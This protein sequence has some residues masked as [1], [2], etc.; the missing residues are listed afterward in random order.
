MGKESV[1]NQTSSE[2]KYG[3]RPDI[4][5]DLNNTASNTDLTGLV[6]SAI[7]DHDEYESYGELFIYQ[8]QDVVVPHGDDNCINN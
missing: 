4:D 1:T 8:P 2:A 6:P 3:I 7:L 5:F